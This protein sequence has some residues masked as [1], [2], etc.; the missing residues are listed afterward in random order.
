VNVSLIARVTDLK[1]LR[2]SAETFGTEPNER[3][4]AAR[5]TARVGIAREGLPFVI[6]IFGTGLV[7]LAT[8]SVWLGTVLVALGAVVG[9]FFR[10]PERAVVAKTNVVLSAA[11]GRV[12]D[13]SSASWPEIGKDFY[14]RVSVF[15]SP[16]DVH[17]NRS[18][19][20]GE[21]EELK[22]FKGDFRA[23][24]RDSA[25]EHNERNLIKIKDEAGKAH[26]LVQIA[27]YLA[28]RIVCHVRAGQRVERGQRIGLI[29]FGSRV[30]HFLPADYRVS[31]AVGD[32]VRAGETII[33]EAAE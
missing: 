29:M 25:S 7:L 13:I 28:R 17:V 18:P 33:G 1:P 14:T 32:H 31:V 9:A 15:M 16:L 24:F 21:V 11:D 6:P 23:A 8:G 22:Y 3:P 27:G 10:D 5:C 30:D 2:H 12:C 26:I 20:S 19:V 4:V